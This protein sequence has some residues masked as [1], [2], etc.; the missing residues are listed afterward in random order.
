[1][2]WTLR[3]TI[4]QKP[5]LHCIDMLQKALLEKCDLEI[6]CPF[7]GKETRYGTIS[8]QKY[9]LCDHCGYSWMED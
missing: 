2:E 4:F 7:C 1:M 8:H 9:I 5:P 3:S 6:P